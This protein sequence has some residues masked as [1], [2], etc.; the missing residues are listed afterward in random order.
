[1]P[2]LARIAGLTTAGAALAAAERLFI[3]S[4]HYTG[5][6]SDHFDG[7]RF[8]NQQSCWQTEGSFLK[9]QVTKKQGWWPDW[10]DTVPGPRPEERVD[11]GR[12][13]VTWINH[14]TMLVQMDGLNI[15]TDPI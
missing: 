13:R 9:W 14:S 8:Q 6:A 4:P 7:K 5:P 3:V 1:M 2:G 12:I 10:I 11:D 15:L